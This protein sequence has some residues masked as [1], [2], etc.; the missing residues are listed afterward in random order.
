MRLSTG[1]HAD[2]LTLQ[3]L[4]EI[5]MTTFVYG[6]D[7]QNCFINTNVQIG[8][9]TVIWPGV[10]IAEGVTIG[11]NCE[12]GKGAT[13]LGQIRI[14]DN[15]KIKHGVEITGKGYIGHDSEIRH[16]IEN[17]QI[18]GHCK[19]EGNVIESI[20]ADYCEIGEGAEIKRSTVGSATKAKH[21]CGIR[22]ADVG[23]CV[24]ISVG[25]EI[26]NSD[27]AGKKRTTVGN[28]VFL[29]GRIEI[30]GGKTIGDEAIISARSL[31]DEDVPAGTYFINMT[32]GLR[33]ATK[34]DNASWYLERNYL[35]LQRS[36]G[37]KY[38]NLFHTKAFIKCGYNT[39]TLKEWLKTPIPH[40]GGR[41]PIQ[42]I[43]EDGEDTF[44]CL[45]DECGYPDK[46][47]DYNSRKTQTNP[48]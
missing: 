9:G 36:I 32:P 2:S 11:K 41:T 25:V 27:G 10:T 40:M 45:L 17:P 5:S 47:C 14:G 35:K 7:L 22:D 24:N 26:L 21:K 1:Y 23:C 42:C 31:V 19:I 34:K 12:I 44:P 28:Y 33:P 29:G 38:R 3:R 20:I 48:D 13:I 37:A 46:P 8:S 6:A 16:D 15:V 30:I 18:G 39:K 43:K 4:H